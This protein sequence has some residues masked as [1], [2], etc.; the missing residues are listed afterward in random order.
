MHYTCPVCN[1]ENNIDLTFRVEEYVCRSCSNHI[2]IDQNISKRIVKKPIENV[3]L[4]VGQKG[5]LQAVEFTVI[6]IVIRKYGT[7]IFWREYALKD[8]SGN[9]LFLSESDGHWVLLETIPKEK[10]ILGSSK[11]LGEYNGKTYRWYETTDCNIH[12][13]A[14]FFEDTLKFSLA[15]YKEYVNGTDMISREQSGSKIEYFKGEHISKNE[16]K[17]A[18]NIPNLPPYSGIGIVQPFYINIKQVIN[19][20]CIAA[21]LICLMQTYV[22]TSRANDTVFQENIY[23][24]NIENKELVSKSFTLLGGSAPLEVRAH[25]AVDNSWANIQLSLVNEKTNETTYVSKDIEKYSGVEGGESWTEGSETEEFNICGVAP[26]TYHFVISAEKQKIIETTIPGSATD[27]VTLSKDPSGIINVLN[28]ATQETTSFGDVKTLESDSSEI[29]NLVKQAFPN[30]NLDSLLNVSP[31]AQTPNLSRVSDE[32]SIDIKA[33]WL[34]VSFWNFG[35]IIALMV[36]FFVICYV[37]KYYFNVSKWKNS[38]NSPY[39]QS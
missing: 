13:A 30:K 24:K 8:K 6:S 2:D 12:S 31:V 36:I 23:F 21:L 7:H 15:T 19:I 29:G 11:T 20:L 38:S 1:T 3:V 14:G 5:I 17:K 37:G 4:E 35:I 22:Y 10:F 34:P 28:N 16:I 27:G 18:F 32:S 33:T 25:T 9:D 26:G 39:P